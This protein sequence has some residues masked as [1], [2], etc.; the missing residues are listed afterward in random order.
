VTARPEHAPELAVL[1]QEAALVRADLHHANHRAHLLRVV[2]PLRL[3]GGGAPP[4]APPARDATAGPA[5][6][7][8]GSALVGDAGP[9][10]APERRPTAGP[11]RAGS[12]RLEAPA[13]VVGGE[14]VRAPAAHRPDVDAASLPAVA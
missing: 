6:P 10:V 11:D 13:G 8:P 1:E 9:A 2:L 3:P 7:G 5:G 14:P 12:A 4:A